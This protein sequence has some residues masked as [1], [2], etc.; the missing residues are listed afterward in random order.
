MDY[1][2]NLNLR[3]K[4]Y[5]DV[6][7]ILVRWKF[8]IIFG[9]GHGI[10]FCLRAFVLTDVMMT[11]FYSNWLATDT[12]VYF[13]EL[14]KFNV[15]IE[16]LKEMVVGIGWTSERIFRFSPVSLSN[17]AR[18]RWGLSKDGLCHFFADRKPFEEESDRLRP[19]WDTSRECLRLS[20]WSPPIIIHVRRIFLESLVFEEYSSPKMV[21]GEMREKGE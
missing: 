4:M 8:A 7:A 2:R 10:S 18:W 9:G 21:T 17:L 11:I 5:L 1:G 13:A 6:F 19:A 20:N 12:N 14:K 3:K 16:N 15:N